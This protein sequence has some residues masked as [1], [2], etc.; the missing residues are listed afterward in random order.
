MLDEEEFVKPAWKDTLKLLNIL[1]D[2]VAIDYT[3]VD[4][5]I[6]SNGI[7]YDYESFVISDSLFSGRSR[8]EGEWLIREVGVNKF[9]WRDSVKLVSDQSFAPCVSI[10]PVPRKTPFSAFLSTRD[11]TS[12]LSWS[13]RPAT[14]SRASTG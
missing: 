10:F 14:S 8:F 3:P 9:T 4:R 7:A 5:A 6:C 2:S 12:G 11:T 1:G 13:S